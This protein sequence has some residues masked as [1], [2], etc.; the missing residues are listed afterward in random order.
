MST[1]K[2]WETVQGDRDKPLIRLDSRVV[3]QTVTFT[4][5]AGVSAAFAS[6]TGVIT[7]RADAACAV[8][9]GETPTA[10]INDYPIDAGVLYDFEVAPGAKISV[11]AT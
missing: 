11:I 7:I 5:T 1:L 9:V 3:Y 8:R 2:I 6:T 4:G 10:V